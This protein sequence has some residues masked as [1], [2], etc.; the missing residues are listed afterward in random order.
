MVHFRADGGGQFPGHQHVRHLFHRLDRHHI[1]GR[2]VL[3]HV[4]VARKHPGDLAKIDAVFLLKDTAG[5]YTSGDCVAPIY[6]NLPTFQIFWRTDAGFGVDQD[7]AVMKGTHKKDGNSR[8]GLPVRLSTDIGSNR[9]LADVELV[10]T[11]HTPKRSD[12]WIDFLKV[13]HE[14][15]RPHGSVLQG[16]IIALR[17]RDGFQLSFSHGVVGSR[18]NGG[19]PL[20]LVYAE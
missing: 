7:S 5:P 9:H 18:L 15:T 6:P 4:L 16:L 10:A 1:D 8:H 3:G 17:A 19:L 2:T 13:E 14:R 12:E 20:C 11:Y